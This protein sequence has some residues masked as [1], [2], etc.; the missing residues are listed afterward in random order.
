MCVV[1]IWFIYIVYMCVS[2][3]WVFPGVHMLQPL[4]NSKRNVSIEPSISYPVFWILGL[5]K[6]WKMHSP[7]P[8]ALPDINV[9]QQQHMNDLVL[10]LDS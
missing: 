3:Y 8:S 1:Y 7:G 2:V 6:A 10:S 5:L 9:S 4:S